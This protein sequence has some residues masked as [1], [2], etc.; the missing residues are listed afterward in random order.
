ME[1]EVAEILLGIKAVTLRANPPYE[2]A[3][4]ILAP[5]YVD[6]R[7]LMS[8]PAERKTIVKCLA[9]VIENM[10]I[11]PDVIAGVATS[12]IP[13]A[14]WVADSLAKPMVYVRPNAKD[15][16]LKNLIE[17]EVERGQHVLVIEDLI[18]TGGSAVSTIKTLR[19]AGGVVE[20][21][22]AIFT[23]EFKKSVQNFNEANCRLITL[24]NFSTLVQ[25]ASEMDYITKNEKE[26]V[27]EW[28]KDPAGW[29]A[30]SKSS[31]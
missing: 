2:W 4:G 13:W 30:P 18:S 20:N 31:R 24:S 16:G 28:S 12:G 23:Y 6:N 9:G 7:M 3:S 22:L 14:A 17:G 11:K 21:C 29:G 5:I 27:L 25:V 19:E 10:G 1:R 8:Y 15:H 26:N